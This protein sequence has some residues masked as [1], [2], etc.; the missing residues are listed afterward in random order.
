MLAFSKVKRTLKLILVV[1]L[2]ITVLL[3]VSSYVLTMVLGL[4]L[5]FFTPEGTYYLNSCFKIS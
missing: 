3:L 2:A 5:F 1:A 4:A